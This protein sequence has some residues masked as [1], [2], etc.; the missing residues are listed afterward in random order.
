[1]KPVIL[2]ASKIVRSLPKQKVILIADKHIVLT[3]H[4]AHETCIVHVYTHTV[5]ILN[6]LECSS[7]NDHTGSCRK[8]K[9]E[10]L[11]GN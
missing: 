3:V 4:N 11:N 6:I 5:S 8:C 9:L 2:L 7:G 1:M 10:R